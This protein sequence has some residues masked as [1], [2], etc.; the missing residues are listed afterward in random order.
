M[1]HLPDSKP[2]KPLSL[3]EMQRVPTAYGIY[4]RGSNCQK[5]SIAWLDDKGIVYPGTSPFAD[6]AAFDMCITYGSE[7]GW[8]TLHALWQSFKA[9]DW[10]TGR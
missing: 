3:A 2:S 8:I 7:D 1:N 6:R 10:L 9:A 5:I 4:G